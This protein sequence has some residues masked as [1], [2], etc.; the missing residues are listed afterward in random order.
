MKVYLV[1]IDDGFYME[2]DVSV[3]KVFKDRLK[4]VRCKNA[5]MAHHRYVYIREF[6]LI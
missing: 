6:D 4:A 2:P 5:L 3:Y 1:M